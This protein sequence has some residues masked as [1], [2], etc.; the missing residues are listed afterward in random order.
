MSRQDNTEIRRITPPK[1]KPNAAT[2]IVANGVGINSRGQAQGG[3]LIFAELDDSCFYC[4]NDTDGTMMANQ[5]KSDWHKCR[6]HLL[7]A[8]SSAG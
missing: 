6:H 4:P 2:L 5:H 8:S 7:L 3:A 1:S